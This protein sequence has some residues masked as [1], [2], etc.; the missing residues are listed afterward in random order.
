MDICEH[1]LCSKEV[2]SIGNRF[3][4]LSC[5]NRRKK[6]GAK[7]RTKYTKQC[8]NENCSVSFSS[9]DK[10]AKYCSR[11]CSAIIFNMNY[12]GRRGPLP[13]GRTVKNPCTRCG[14]ETV[15]YRGQDDLCRRCFSETYIDRWLE[16]KES[17]TTRYGATV[18]V[19]NYIHNLKGMKCWECGWDKINP[20]TGKC[21]V[22][23]DHIDGDAMN[24]RPENL[25]LLCPNCH[26]LTETF[27]YT[28]MKST[29]SYRYS[30]K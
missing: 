24:N 6:K 22:Q 4:S 7:G 27:G 20:R 15:G 13:T 8:G 14:R 2:K 5:A 17:G 25:R 28:G 19:R 26:S 16:G 9:E 21:T 10:N 30:K 3:C 23:I 29:R 18:A 11:T 1:P 12:E